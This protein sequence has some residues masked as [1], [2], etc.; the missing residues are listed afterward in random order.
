MSLM[1]KFR[2]QTSIMWIS[3]PGVHLGDDGE[4][5]EKAREVNEYAAASQKRDFADGMEQLKILL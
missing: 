4:A 1:D 5:R 3:T 2:I